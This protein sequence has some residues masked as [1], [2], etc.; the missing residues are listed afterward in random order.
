MQKA[1]PAQAQVVII[2]GGI[3]GG[4]V[5]Y[6]LTRMGWKGLNIAGTK[7]SDLRR[8]L[9]RSRFGGPTSGHQGLEHV[10]A[11]LHRALRPSGGGNRTGR[12]ALQRIRVQGL[13]RR[14]AIFTVDD[15]EPLLYH[16]EPIYRNRVLVGR[17]THGAYAHHLGRAMG[18][19]YLAGGD[20]GP[21]EEWILDGRYEINVEG[22]MHQVRVH[23]KAPYDPQGK[24]LRM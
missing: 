6:H 12:Q 19:T 24:R 10:G 17:N 21:T 1:L 11:L 14:L 22:R 15:P 3:I 2:G 18:M 13:D 9:G 4:S 20:D 7:G 5:A 16:D 8:H 23:L